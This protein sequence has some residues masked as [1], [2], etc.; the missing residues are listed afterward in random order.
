MCS[1]ESA[2]YAKFIQINYRFKI[3]P[4]RT[5][6]YLEGGMAVVAK[7]QLTYHPM[8]HDQRVNGPQRIAQRGEV[9]R[10]DPHAP[11]VRAVTVRTNSKTFPIEAHL[12]EV[13]ALSIPQQ[14]APPVIDNSRRY[15]AVE[16]ADVQRMLCVAPYYS[17][18]KMCEY[19]HDNG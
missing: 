19:M 6:S 5:L 4:S 17:T 13:V 8:V 7:I 15:H 18:D 2:D 12:R 10:V 11:C 9:D 1:S 14:V 3:I 16:L